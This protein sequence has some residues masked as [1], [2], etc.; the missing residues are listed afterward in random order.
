[1]TYNIPQEASR[2]LTLARRNINQNFNLFLDALYQLTFEPKDELP[3][4]FATNGVSLFY[5]PAVVV[6]VY[7]NYG[8]KPLVHEIL[9]LC[10][11]CFLGHLAM[12]GSVEDKGLFDVIADYKVEKLLESL[13]K[14]EKFLM[15]HQR[16]PSKHRFPQG[17]TPLP[18]AYNKLKNDPKQAGKYHKYAQCF[19]LDNHE[20]WKTKGSDVEQSALLAWKS[21]FDKIK[22]KS[23]QSMPFG[24]GRNYSL[25]EPGNS[26]WDFVM[27]EKSQM[28]YQT[29]LAKFLTKQMSEEES[30][31]SLDPMWYHF[32]LEYL[33]DIPMIEPGEEELTPKEGTLVLAIDTSGSCEGEICQQFLRELDSILQE[34]QGIEHLSKV[35]LLQCDEVI[36]EEIVMENASQ[37]AETVANYQVK[38]GGGTDFRPVFQR[39]EEFSDVVGMIYLSDGQGVFPDLPST[40]P[41]LFL[42]TEEMNESFYYWQAVPDWVE[43]THIAV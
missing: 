31:L 15:Q 29:I 19:C 18:I 5:N 17:V 14:E 43:H 13:C 40:I 39:A 22:E 28:D 34:L 16:P 1:M 24:F 27:G 9:H 38:G 32:G 41:T 30:L 20:L 12:R 33:G 11:H 23:T 35:V 6:Q 10:S 21:I 42:L 26:C 37:W 7:E 4:L 2:I 8:L 25:G 3:E 36:Q